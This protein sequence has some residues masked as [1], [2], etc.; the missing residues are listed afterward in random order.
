MKIRKMRIKP[1]E[2]RSLV[3]KILGY[4]LPYKTVIHH[5]DGN[6]FNNSI[7]NLVVCENDAYHKLLHQRNKAIKEC[8][9]VDWRKCTIC[10]K[11]DR[12]ENLKKSGSAIYHRQCKAKS[13]R[14]SYY[15][16]KS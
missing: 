1:I 12:P 16:C 14:D 10:K 8:G 5:I 15:R 9:H 6:P 7:R 4:K 11:Y 3:E 13:S 2:Y